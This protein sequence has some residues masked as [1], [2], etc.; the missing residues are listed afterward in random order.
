M[1][2]TWLPSLAEISNA[3]L[4]TNT[5]Q[6]LFVA[7]HFRLQRR[8]SLTGRFHCWIVAQP[9]CT[10]RQS[11]PRLATPTPVM[12]LTPRSE[13]MLPFISSFT[14]HCE[15]P[16]HWGAGLLLLHFQFCKCETT[17]IHFD[18]DIW[19]EFE[20]DNLHC[21]TLYHLRVVVIRPGQK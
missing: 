9:G 11:R 18:F 7:F 15:L 6:D 17:P 16:D 8:I 4:S 10:V 14:S 20:P 5:N 12:A 2:L 21:R 19:N 1:K 13:S 3:G